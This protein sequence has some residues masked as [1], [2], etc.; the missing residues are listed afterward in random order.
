M[1]NRKIF[2]VLENEACLL[3][4]VSETRYRLHDDLDEELVGQ[5]LTIEGKVDE[6]TIRTPQVTRVE[7]NEGKVVR[8]GVIVS[9]APTTPPFANGDSLFLYQKSKGR[10]YLL[11]EGS[12]DEPVGG[13]FQ[14][15]EG[16]T[17]KVTGELDDPAYILY[18]TRI[19]PRK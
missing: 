18:R 2:G 19:S 10:Y 17:V 9:Q 15:Y 16:M 7:K 3:D 4:P 8:T 12:P 14:K 1:K 5:W 13:D 6:D 11:S